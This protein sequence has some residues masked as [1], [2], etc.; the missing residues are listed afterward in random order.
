MHPVLVSIFGLEIKTYGVIVAVAFLA[1]IYLASM[2]AEREGIKK[3]TII[4][5]GIVI[6]ICALLGARILYVLIWWKDYLKHPLDIFK[7]WEGGLVYYGGFLMA[8]AG[9]LWWLKRN[10]LPFLKVTDILTPFLALGHSIARIG[11]FCSG[12]CYGRPDPH[13]II[14]KSIGDNIPH[15]PTQLY[16]SAANFLNFIVLIL[17][18]RYARRKQGDVFYL[19]LLNYG[20]IRTLIELFRADPERGVILGL[21]T[22]TFISIFLILGGAA[23]L[24][25]NR[26]ANGK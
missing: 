18:Y 5:L 20:V 19:Y 13:G 22:S 6:I 14:F 24:I 2:L 15:L 23:G 21:S 4:D 16:E 25:Y 9:V 7:V 1:G 11:C 17:F 26:V 10:K 3:D 8:V 12:C